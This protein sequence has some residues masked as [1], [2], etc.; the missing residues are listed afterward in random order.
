MV[1]F[2]Q[3]CDMLWL[4]C[5]SQ[6]DTRENVLQFLRIQMANC[7]RPPA[8][9]DKWQKK[10]ISSIAQLTSQWLADSPTG[11]VLNSTVGCMDEGST[12]EDFILILFCLT[13]ILLPVHLMFTSEYLSL[14]CLDKTQ[15]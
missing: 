8:L 3:V 10:H 2:A 5:F 9:N 12:G 14:S 11:S 7:T 13:A 4:Y 6:C 15:Y 1:V